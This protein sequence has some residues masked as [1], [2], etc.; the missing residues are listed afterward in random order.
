M[1]RGTR[2]ESGPL[3]RQAKAALAEAARASAKLAKENGPAVAA[4]AEALLACFENGG[5]VYFCG[6]GGSAADAQH[7]AAEFS[8]RY[9]VDRPG[10]PAV[11]LTTNSSAVTAIG[12]DYG[13]A[14]VFA[15]QLEGLG[16]PRHEDDPVAPLGAYGR[17]KLAGEQGVREANARH[18]VVRTS[19]LY[20]AGGKNFVDTILSRARA[21]GAL[22]VVDDQRG[23]PTWTAD[24]A[25]ALVALMG[26][27][28]YGTYHVTG[29][30]DCTWHGFAT[31]ICEEAGV[32]TEVAAITSEDL[33]RAARRPAYSVMDN[34]HYE[35]VTGRRMPH[36][37]DALRRYLRG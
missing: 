15:R 18:L 7:L 19:W 28:S 32:A 4:A 20:G 22:R 35:R 11:A 25:D 13:Y 6:N 5:T 31:A 9:L 34:G 14:D 33:G 27:R 24:L 3:E 2:T 29:S 30:G 17:S 12:N 1:A 16:A 23:S 36:W 26:A 10:L 37:R 8:G 21:G